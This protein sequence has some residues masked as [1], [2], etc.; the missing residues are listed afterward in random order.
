MSS[1]GAVEDELEAG[2]LHFEAGKTLRLGTASSR[3]EQVQAT[4]MSGGM[5]GEALEERL[6]AIGVD[7]VQH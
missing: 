6:G 5:A 4:A 2:E 7:Q 3:H 1:L